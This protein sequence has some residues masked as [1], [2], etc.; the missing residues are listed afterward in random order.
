MARKKQSV[1]LMRAKDKK[2]AKQARE[3][4]LEKVLWD[5]PRRRNEQRSGLLERLKPM[6][7]DE[8]EEEQ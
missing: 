4:E 3:D 7:E 8:D 5:D 1:I 6:I 2:K